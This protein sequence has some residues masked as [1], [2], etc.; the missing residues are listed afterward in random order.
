MT[1]FPLVTTRFQKPVYFVR[2]SLRRY[3]AVMNDWMD[4]CDVSDLPPGRR[5]CERIEN[6]PVVMLNA[7][8]QL[9][10]LENTCP[11]A[12]LPLHDGELR[13]QTITCPH[14]GY[15]FRLHDGSDIDDPHGTPVR[16][17]EVRVEMGRVKVRG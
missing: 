7:D 13:G 11:H 17:F 6:T 8:G 3:D 10:C 4:V 5:R 14:H 12:G 16:V 2:G 9:H 15:T 1:Y